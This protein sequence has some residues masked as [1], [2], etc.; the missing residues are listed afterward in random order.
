[1]Q[2]EYFIIIKREIAN[3]LLQK[4]DAYR[5][6]MDEIKQK[7]L[8]DVDP[9]IHRQKKREKRRYR[10]VVT[11]EFVG[12]IVVIMAVFYI[13]MGISTVQGNSMYPTL[14]NGERVIYNR[15]NSDYKVGDVIVLK[16][17]NGEEFVKRI[18][19]VAGDTVN[20]QNGKLYVNGEEEKLDGPIGETKTS[21]DSDVQYPVTVEDNQVFVMGDNR[22]VS[23]D[24]RMFGAVSL[25]DVK[26]KITWYLG[27]L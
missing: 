27:R 7:V 25:D 23:E 26:G 3:E 12:L 24:S 14:H 22:E 4:R 19:A 15:R 21:D 5:M 13:L 10:A 1:M 16:R 17:P 8:E 6:E 18:V 9:E 20:I 11:L 2:G